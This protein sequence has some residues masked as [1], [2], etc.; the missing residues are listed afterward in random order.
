MLPETKKLYTMGH[1][2][3]SPCP[4]LKKLMLP[5]STAAMIIAFFPVFRATKGLGLAVVFSLEDE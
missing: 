4:N 1:S 2:L 5:I 3:N